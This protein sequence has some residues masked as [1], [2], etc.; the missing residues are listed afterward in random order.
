MFEGIGVSMGSL[1]GGL[2]MKSIGG[3]ATFKLFSIAAFICFIGHVLIQ[4][5]LTRISGPY[6]KK[7]S[8]HNGI[9]KSNETLEINAI[10]NN[11]DKVDEHGFKDIDLSGK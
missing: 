6:G 8:V 3:S 4:W 7:S 11:Q 2:L 1:I 10:E 9:S 5:L